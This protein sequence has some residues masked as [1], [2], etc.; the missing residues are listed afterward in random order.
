MLNGEAAVR[1]LPSAPLW[2]DASPEYHKELSEARTAQRAHHTRLMEHHMKIWKS[3]WAT[4]QNHIPLPT[5]AQQA[6]LDKKR[7][8]I[9]QQFSKSG[10]FTSN[11]N[12]HGENRASQLSFQPKGTQCK[13]TGV[14]MWIAK[15]DG[16][17]VIMH[18][19]L[20][21]GRNELFNQVKTN[22]YRMIIENSAKLKKLTAWLMRAEY[23][24]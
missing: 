11:A 13:L 16:Q 9:P 20:I 8:K 18:C 1:L 2:Y 5:E 7:L 21:D 6:S 19:Q 17:T 15:A 3:T 23:T 22:N 14:H 4:Y 10:E 12:S 24:K